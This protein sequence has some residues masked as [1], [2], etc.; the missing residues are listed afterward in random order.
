MVNDIA[1]ALYWLQ[2]ISSP[3]L[4]QCAYNVIAKNLLHSII[5]DKDHTNP[6]ESHFQLAKI[7]TFVL[8]KTY[9]GFN[10]AASL[11]RAVTE[12]FQ[13]HWGS[14]ISTAQFQ[15]TLIDLLQEVIQ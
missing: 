10:D 8:F 4:L 2:D 1:D 6:L 12:Y 3:H 9:V 15:N 14:R 11:L 5:V 7:V 13:L